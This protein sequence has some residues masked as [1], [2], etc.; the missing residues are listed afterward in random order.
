MDLT[1]LIA[2]GYEDCDL[3]LKKVLDALA[4]GVVLVDRNGIVQYINADAVRTLE[5]S[6]EDT[7][8]R[9]LWEVCDIFRDAFSQ[10]VGL[11]ENATTICEHA[12]PEKRVRFSIAPIDG[13]LF[14][15]QVSLIGKRDDLG[16]VGDPMLRTSESEVQKRRADECALEASQQFVQAVLDNIDAGIVACDETGTLTLFNNAAREFH[17]IPEA[18]LQAE[19]WPAHYD[20]YYPDGKRLLQKEDIPLYIAPKNGRRR[21]V[22]A[23]GRALHAPDGRKLGAVVAMQDITHRKLSSMRIRQALRQFRALFNDAPIAY[24][25]VDCQGIIRRVNRA[26]QRQS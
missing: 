5:I 11:S 14:V 12:K 17:G 22:L 6:R 24:H 15:I 18:P 7:Q 25:E 8:Q 9:V 20:L 26:D 23:S 4:I 19:N 1:G 10:R 2:M 13:G 3:D 16:S 21:T